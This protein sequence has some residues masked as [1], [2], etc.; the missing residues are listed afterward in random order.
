MVNFIVGMCRL[1]GAL[2]KQNDKASK[3]NHCYPVKYAV[4]ADLFILRDLTGDPD[5]RFNLAV[6]KAVGLERYDMAEYIR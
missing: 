3:D 1:G 5:V 4:H 6:H 2:Q